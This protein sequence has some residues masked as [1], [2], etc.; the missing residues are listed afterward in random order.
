MEE[1]SLNLSES[2][3]ES[4]RL[5]D[6]GFNLRAV[7]VDKSHAFLQLGHMA[8]FSFFTK[9]PMSDVSFCGINVS[10]LNCVL[11]SLYSCTALF[12]KL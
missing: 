9:G 1:S 5:L 6:L 8:F 4:L 12:Y 7:T 2:S 11:S 10:V 3:H